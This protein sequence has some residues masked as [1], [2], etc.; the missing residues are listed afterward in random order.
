[1]QTIAELLR[2]LYKERYAGSFFFTSG[3]S[4]CDQGSALF[5]TLAYQIAIYVPG[6]REA[7]NNAMIADITLPTK[8]MEIQI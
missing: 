7:V 2:E 8:S 1:M 4:G 5:S 3:K 6:M